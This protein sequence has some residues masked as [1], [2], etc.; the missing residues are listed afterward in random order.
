MLNFAKQID[1]Y[2]RGGGYN[3]TVKMHAFYV[4]VRMGAWGNSKKKEA[5]HDGKN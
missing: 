5:T 1:K 3:E 4:F 2:M